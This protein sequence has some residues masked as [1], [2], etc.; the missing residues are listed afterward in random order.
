MKSGLFIF[1][2]LGCLLRLEAQTVVHK[3]GYIRVTNG[4]HIM[5][6]GDYQTKDDAIFRTKNL[7][8]LKVNGNW[9][10]DANSAYFHDNATKVDFSS[11]IVEVKGRTLTNFPYLNL[12][13]KGELRLLTSMVV[14]GSRNKGTMGQLRVNDV[15]IHLQGRT[16]ILNNPLANAITYQTGGGIISETNS[17]LGYGVVQWNIREGN[18][19]PVFN[20]PMLNASSDDVSVQYILNNMGASPNDSGYINTSTYPTADLPAPNNRPLPLGVFNT[21]NECDGENSTRFANRYWIIESQGYSTLPDVTLNFKYSETDIKGSN[22]EITETYIGG[23]QWNG[24]NNKWQYPL[25][26]RIDPVGNSF[27]YRAKQNFGGIWT[28]SDTTPYPRAQ[29]SVLGFCQK[30]SIIF[31]DNS[32]ESNDKIIQRQ[33]YF[34]DGGVDNG[35]QLVHFYQNSG[36]FDTRLIIRSQSGCQD[37]AEKRIMVQASPTANFTLIDTCENAW[38]KGK[39]MSWPGAGF[40]EQ[41]IWNFGMGEPKQFG[42]EAQYYYGAVGL[43]E[44]SLIVYNS[45]GCKDTAIQYPFI[46]PKP[47]AFALFENECQGTPITFTNGSNAGGGTL[48]SHYW[49]FGNGVRSNLGSE[50]VTYNTFGMFSVIYAVENSYGC[51]DSMFRPIEI[52]PRAVADF[53]YA[54]EDPEMLKPIQFQSTSLYADQWEWSFGDSYF[55]LEENP[56]HSYENHGRYEVSLVANTLFGCSDTIGKWINIKSTPLYWFVNA[57]TPGTTEGKNDEFGIETPLKIHEYNMRIINR[58]G[59]EVF[60]ST[61]P[62]NKWNGKTNGRLCPSGNYIY[63][64]TFKSPE[65]EIMTYKGTVILLR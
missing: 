11:A 59:Q 14:G 16:L 60:R 35:K 34:G 38:V 25:K 51:K 53:K 23:I 24:A 56:I 21:D 8:F 6:N 48:T 57:F 50:T 42:S 62:N 28:L 3:G 64:V 55:A 9:I 29:Y 13:G 17:S 12:S 47:N 63:H 7:G 31:S 58:W 43:P 36:P 15:K 40:I 65:N 49:N 52:Y 20:I 41:S 44:I 27:T 4:A 26:G 18:G 32:I 54:P 1:G 39:S 61:D 22:D 10:N 37:T 33:W 19:G 45:K 2:I 46:A 5:V 30:D